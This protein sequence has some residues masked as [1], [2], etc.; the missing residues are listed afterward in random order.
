M[1]GFIAKKLCPHL[2]IVNPNYKEYQRTSE[3]VRAVLARYDPNFCPVGLDESYLDITEHVQK[4]VSETSNTRLGKS[5]G[6]DCRGRSFSESEGDIWFAN[7]S[8][9]TDYRDHSSSGNEEDVCTCASESNSTDHTS[10][11]SSE[12][13]KYILCASKSGG[14]DR[15]DCSSSEAKEDIWCAGNNSSFETEKDT[16]CASKSNGTDRKDR[17]SSDTE[18]D[19][20]DN[21]DSYA[22]SKLHWQHAEQVVCEMRESIFR[23]TGITASAGIAPNK[24]LAKVASDLNKPN[25]QFLVEPTREGVLSFVQDLPIRKVRQ[26]VGERK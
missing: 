26:E 10:H 23:A 11:P 9:Q 6:A 20:W 5:S 7:N 18:E 17:S 14:T 2:V 24:M 12:T 22:L 21:G 19:I 16:V 1:P 13:R 3:Q 8:F 15:K 25:G 4:R